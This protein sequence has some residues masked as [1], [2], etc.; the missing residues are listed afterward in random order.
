MKSPNR[1]LEVIRRPSV[2]LLV[3]AAW[4]LPANQEVRMSGQSFHLPA[5]WTVRT[6]GQYAAIGS[7]SHTYNPAGM[8]WVTVTLCD[9][10]TNHPCRAKNANPTR[11]K[12]CLALMKSLHE[13]PDGIRETGWVCP[14][15]LDHPPA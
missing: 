3:A 14:L 5:A 15:M 11:D 4:A 8:S 2:R 7:L 9:N 6:E 13:S 12:S 10:T 1:S